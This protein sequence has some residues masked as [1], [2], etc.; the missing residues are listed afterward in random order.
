MTE[1]PTLHESVEEVALA[2][3]TWISGTNKDLAWV[4]RRA[5]HGDHRCANSIQATV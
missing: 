1:F 5:H 3:T 4:S 2:K